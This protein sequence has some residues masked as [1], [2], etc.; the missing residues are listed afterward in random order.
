MS[1]SPPVFSHSPPIDF[2]SHNQNCY[3]PLRDIP[4]IRRSTSFPV[5]CQPKPFTK[6]SKPILIIRTPEESSSDE[7]NLS[8]TKIKKKVVFADDKGMS[9]THVRLMSEPSNVPPLWTKRFLYEVTRGLSADSVKSD[10]NWEITFSQPASD[11]VQFRNRLDKQN[12]CLEN[13]IIKENEDQIFGTI[14]VANLSY[15]KTIFVRSSCDD[16]STHQDISCSYVPNS[17]SSS[18]ATSAY[19]IYDTFT[20]NL[21]LPTKSKRMEFCICFRSGQTEY[22]DNNE[23]KNYLLL[24]RIQFLPRMNSTDSFLNSPNN[25]PA[26]NITSTG[27]SYFGNSTNTNNWSEFA[28]WSHY[29]NSGP[30]W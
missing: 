16:W 9:L 29:E 24:K 2:L 26:K 23:N 11:Y 21:N 25:T 1:H 5:K 8:P 12:V 3:T 13:V 14:K 10:I 28:S 22:W 30:Y 18:A 7:D 15:E 17:L 27:N 20:F 4:R 6:P 19:V